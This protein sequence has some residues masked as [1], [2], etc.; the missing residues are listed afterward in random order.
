MKLAPFIRMP[1]FEAPPIPLKNV[2]GTL[3][4]RAHGHDTTR[5]MSARCSHVGSNAM[6]WPDNSG[7]SNA[8]TTAAATTMGV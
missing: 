1:R 8:T 6:K 2:S 7:G 3:M 5:K 4:T